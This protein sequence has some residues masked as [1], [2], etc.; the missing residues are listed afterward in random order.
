MQGKLIIFSAPSGAGK[1]TLV[2]HLLAQGLPLSFSISACTR[3]PRINEVNGEDYHFI[4]LDSFKE[5]IKAGEFLEWEQVYEDVYYG[6]LLAELERIWALGKH[7]IFDV[8]VKGG[9]KIK[10]IFPTQSLAIFVMP[11]SVEQLEERIRNRK[12][13]TTENIEKRISKATYELE[14]ANEFDYILLNDNLEIAK[15][16]AYTIVADFLNVV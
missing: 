2:K 8:D 3:A 12:T 10:N 15:S 11:P 5:K 14:F 9:L 1:T 13:E 7:V 16:E 4:S 6:T